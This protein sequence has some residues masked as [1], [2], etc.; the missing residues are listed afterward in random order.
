[1]RM[2]PHSEKYKRKRMINSETYFKDKSKLSIKKGEFC[3]FE[4]FDKD[5]LFLNNFGMAIQLN[6][7][8][9]HQGTK[10]S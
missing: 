1:M 10:A 3:L 5:P 9:Y 6:Q 7:F 2:L 4:H 8:I